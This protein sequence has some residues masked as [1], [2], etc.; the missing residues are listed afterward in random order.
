[1]VEHLD[2]SSCVRFKYI[3]AIN[4]VD[5]LLPSAILADLVILYCF[6]SILYILLSALIS[7][8]FC[9]FSLSITILFLH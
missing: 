7:S 8:F 6:Q 5:D 3:C 9:L 2:T 4:S 1:M